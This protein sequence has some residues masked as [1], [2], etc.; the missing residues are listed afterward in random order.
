MIN[1][2]RMYNYAIYWYSIH[3]HVAEGFACSVGH[4]V[5]VIC[6]NQLYKLFTVTGALR[7]SRGSVTSSSFTSGRLEIFLSGQWGTVCDDLWG[8]TDSNVAC[9]QLG[10]PSAT[11]FRT[12]IFAGWGD[13]IANSC[14]IPESCM[15][16][17]SSPCIC[18]SWKW[19]WPGY[20][21]IIH[22]CLLPETQGHQN[23][24]FS[25]IHPLVNQTPQLKLSSANIIVL[26]PDMVLVLDQSGW[27]MWVVWALNWTFSPAQTMELEFTT[28]STQR[29]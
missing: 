1:C 7:L 3:I 10:F 21:A 29:I 20:V 16:V 26:S 5:I 13:C 9:R 24:T 19:Q 15:H 23:H 25:A 8:L 2:C 17:A 11:S 14:L 6:N 27:I 18:C 28:V 12:S 22:N 4:W